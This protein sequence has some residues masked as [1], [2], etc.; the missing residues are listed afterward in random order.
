MMTATCTMITMTM[1]AAGD[2]VAVGRMMGRMM[3]DQ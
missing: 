1:T 3:S 2:V